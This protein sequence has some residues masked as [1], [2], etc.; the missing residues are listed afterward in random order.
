MTQAVSCVII[1]LQILGH[2]VLQLEQLSPP[3]H[4]RHTQI[5]QFVF[6]TDVNLDILK[7]HHP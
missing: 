7:Q 1:Y 3:T 6:Q 2:T 4:Y 5:N